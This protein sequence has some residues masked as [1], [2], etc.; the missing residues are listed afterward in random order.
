MSSP[1]FLNKHPETGEYGGA[2]AYGESASAGNAVAEYEAYRTNTSRKEFNGNAYLEWEPLKDLKL[3]VSYALRYYNQFSKSIQNV[4]NQMNFQTNSIAR[5]MPDTG[6]IISN[7]NNEGHKTL[8]QGRI[9]YEKEIFKGH[10]ISAMF[11]AAEE[12]WFQRNMGAGRKNRLHNS[13]EELDA[14]SKEVQTN[15]GKSESKV[16]VLS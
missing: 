16:C 8:F 12:Y 9:T 14:A 10:H 4:V 5:T 7:S 2:M 3:N 15:D 1:V 13:L 6:D 11:N